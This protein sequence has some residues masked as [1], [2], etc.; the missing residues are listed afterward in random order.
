MAEHG[1]VEERPTVVG[2]QQGLSE[3][4]GDAFCRHP[5]H[6]GLE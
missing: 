3:N 2:E 4:G 5:Q 6:R 1:V